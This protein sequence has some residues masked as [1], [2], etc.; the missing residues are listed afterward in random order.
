MPFEAPQSYS[1]GKVVRWT[2][3]AESGGG[4]SGNPASVLKLT[5]KGAGARA[6]AP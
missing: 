2:E 6:A 1:D 4:E 5:A 3:E